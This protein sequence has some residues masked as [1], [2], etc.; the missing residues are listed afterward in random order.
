L[1]YTG[2]LMPELKNDL[3]VSILGFQPLERQNLMRVRFEDPANPDRP[4]AIERWF[5][6]A[7]GNSVYGRLRALAIGPDGAIYVGT[8]NHDGRQMTASHREI[9]DRILRISPAQ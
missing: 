3:F 7:Q 2:D 6:D 9:P 8:S 4:T 1:F 5:N